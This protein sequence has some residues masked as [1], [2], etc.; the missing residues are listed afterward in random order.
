[1]AK[2]NNIDK[3]GFCICCQ[4][5]LLKNVVIKG[6]QEAQFTPDKDEVWL[7]LNTGSMMSI[8]VC[9]NCKNTLDF[10]DADMKKEILD[11][12]QNGWT[13]EMDMMT[14]NPAQFPDFTTDKRQGAQNLYASIIDYSW[15]KDFKA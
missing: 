12:V 6:K 1:M 4:K 11:A 14:L 13:I 9:R 10:N 3:F 15:I 2:A 7:K 5:Y 8:S